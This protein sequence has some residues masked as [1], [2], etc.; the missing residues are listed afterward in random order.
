MSLTELSP[1]ADLITAFATVAAF[2]A[3]A[4]EIRK[5]RQIENRAQILET[6]KMFQELSSDRKRASSM[7]WTDYQDFTRKYPV[8]SDEFWSSQIILEFFDTIG[9]SIRHGELEKRPML[10][11][12]GT[13]ATFY[14]SKFN[15]IILA[16]NKEND[17]ESFDDLEWFAEE[18]MKAHPELKPEVPFQGNLPIGR[19]IA[20]VKKL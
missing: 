13:K 9:D 10:R 2:L 1:I 6:K 3:V 15:D 11:L 7:T 17:V 18:T 19:K 5:S 12:W 8:T 16:R 4:Y 14:W 20:K